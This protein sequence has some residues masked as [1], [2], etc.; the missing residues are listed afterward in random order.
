MRL[1]EQREAAIVARHAEPAADGSRGT[2]CRTAAVRSTGGRR[3]ERRRVD[4][5][6]GRDVPGNGRPT[7]SARR[8][9]IGYVPLERGEPRP[10]NRATTALQRACKLSG[11]RL[12]GVVTDRDSDRRSLDRPGMGYALDRIA[13]WL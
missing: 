3:P 1:V 8:N 11:W 13:P 2:E 6:A 10:S 5:S 7:D 9:V 12:V 4:R